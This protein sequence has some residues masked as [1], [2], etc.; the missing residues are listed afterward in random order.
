MEVVEAVFLNGE[1]GWKLAHELQDANRWRPIAEARE[2][3]WPIVLIDIHDPG[4][5]QLSYVCSLSW[6]VES[7]GMTHFSKIAPLSYEQADALI[8]AL[9]DPP[10]GA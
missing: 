10:E 4:R 6:T 1:A 8:A 3:D 5:L 7:L 2:D 9:P